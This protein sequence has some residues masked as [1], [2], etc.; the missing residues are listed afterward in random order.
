MGFGFGT[1]LHRLRTGRRVARLGWN[2]T[3]M[4]LV[5]VPGSSITV[6]ATRPVGRAVPELVGERVSYRAHI[7]MMTA[8]GTLVPWVASQTDVL[9]FDWYDVEDEEDARKERARI[10][11]AAAEEDDG[12]AHSW[13]A[14]GP[15]DAYGR[16]TGQTVTAEQP[17]DDAD[18]AALFAL[19]TGYVAAGF[20]QC[21]AIDLIAAI[22]AADARAR[23][24]G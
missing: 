17:P 2:G 12:R 9:S 1:A 7:D 15:T 23:Q 24:E 10:A 16:S 11:R 5:L 3:G 20:T 18:M 19:F 13:K 8:D 21:Q 6:E 4:W 22:S 14:N